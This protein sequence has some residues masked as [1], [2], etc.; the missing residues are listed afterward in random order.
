MPMS[1]IPPGWY[2]D[3]ENATQYRYWDGTTWSEHRSPKVVTAP[4]ATAD[5]TAVITRGFDLFKQTWVQQL[6]VAVI[7][8]LVAAVGIVIAVVAALA[9]LDPDLFDIIDRVTEPG[10]DPD[11]DPDDEAFLDSITFDW[12]AGAIV[13]IVFGGLLAY[14]AMGVGFA[15][16]AVHVARVNAGGSEG[17]GAS[18]RYCLRNLVRWIGIALLWGL[19]ATLIIAVLI[20]IWIALIALTPATLILLIP[21]TLAGIIYAWPYL[22]IASTVLVLAPRDVGPAR[23]T[24][25]LVKPKWP[26]F[27]GRVL[28]VTIVLIAINIT[29]NILALIPLLGILI[30]LAASFVV[31]AY[32]VATNVAL[33]DYLEGPLAEDLKT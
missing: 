24:V 12:N 32:Q 21:A 15:T 19:V 2:D 20:G 5:A 25:G 17:L 13:G 11:N 31:Y 18:F 30:T 9:N 10:W 6:I 27:A 3:P 29:T 22:H 7:A 26:G 33:Y 28:L 8:G 16:A 1:D 23:R 14:F 4:M